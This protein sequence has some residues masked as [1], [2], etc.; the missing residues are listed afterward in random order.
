M[1]G[2]QTLLCWIPQQVGFLAGRWPYTDAD[3]LRKNAL[4]ATATFTAGRCFYL[5]VLLLLR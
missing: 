5:V 1:G 3:R 2:A 4:V